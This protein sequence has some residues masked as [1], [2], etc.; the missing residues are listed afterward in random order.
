ML[1]VFIHIIRNFYNGTDNVYDSR[2]TQEVWQTITN[3][4]QEWKGVY[5]NKV[6]LTPDILFEK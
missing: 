5:G 4:K 2:S 6:A 3:L 1:D